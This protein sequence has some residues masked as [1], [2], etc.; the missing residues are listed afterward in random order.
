VNPDKN[1]V[2]DSSQAVFVNHDIFFFSDSTARARFLADPLKYAH[3]LSDVVGLH[4]FAPNAKSPHLVYHGRNY[5]FE[6][7]ATYEQFQTNPPTYA[8]RGG[9]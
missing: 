5:Y 6:S 7:A 4:R 1:A 9:E 2:I 3:H 8:V